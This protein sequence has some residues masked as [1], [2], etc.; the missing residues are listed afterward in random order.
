MR[1]TDPPFHAK[2]TEKIREVEHEWN[3]LFAGFD[4]KRHPHLFTI[5]EG[6]KICFCDVEGYAAIGSGAWRGL[7][8]LSSYPFT[9]SLPLS[10]AIFGIAAAKFAA[11]SADGVGE[12]TVLA[13]L[14]PRT[15]QS[16]A[17]NDITVRSLR[18][19]WKALPRFPGQDATAAI[20]KELTNFQGLGWLSE[21]KPLK[22]SV[23]EKL[24]LGP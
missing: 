15:Q 2:V 24:T 17:F 14:E 21:N 3:L 10:H 1:A 23:A 12:E 11:E 20:W 16:P 4:R 9:R 13:V 22:P 18:H 6:G 19:M 5:T 7:V 8:A